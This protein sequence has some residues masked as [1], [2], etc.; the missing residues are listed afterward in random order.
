[1]LPTPYATPLRGVKVGRHASCI[2]RVAPSSHCH[3]QACDSSI[4][5]H[6]GALGCCMH[7]AKR[8]DVTRAACVTCDSVTWT[9]KH[10]RNTPRLQC[11]API[12]APIV[13]PMHA[14]RDTKTRSILHAKKL[15]TGRGVSTTGSGVKVLHH[16]QTRAKDVAV[17]NSLHCNM[18]H[19]VVV[20]LGSPSS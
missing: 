2:A 17:T 10:T 3:T 11:L 12:T 7:R 8:A 13:A 9:N 18:L 1:M 20:V 5:Q 15:S 14:T 19:V 16:N 6:A 4:P